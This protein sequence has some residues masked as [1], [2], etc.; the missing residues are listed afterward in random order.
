MEKFQISVQNKN[1]TK[2]FKN[3]G[4]ETIKNVLKDFPLEEEN[5]KVSKDKRIAYNKRHF[6]YF[7]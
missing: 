5:S 7:F 1:D 6:Y 2:I 3:F 4:M